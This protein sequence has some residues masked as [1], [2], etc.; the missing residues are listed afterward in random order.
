MNDLTQNSVLTKKAWHETL[1]G[2]G[3]MVTALAT[4]SGTVAVLY[5]KRR[6]RKAQEAKKLKRQKEA[7][8]MEEGLVKT[9]QQEIDSENELKRV[10][11]EIE[12]PRALILKSENGGGVPRIGKGVF[13]TIL[14]EASDT[15][16]DSVMNEVKRLP[17]D[18]SYNK[19]IIELVTNGMQIL[20]VD[21][22]E[23]GML[24]DIYLSDGIKY[25]IVVPI[26]TM[27]DMFI[28]A[29]FAWKSVLT[30]EMLIQVKSK[31]VNHANNIKNIYER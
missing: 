24:K 6:E 26:V 31:I 7:R 30:D 21:E 18:M 25:S 20:I 17:T 29:S 13:L 2:V 19:L 9:L 14:H 11:H 8:L 16:Y 15:G 22:M 3:T 4:A 23:D 10:K 5:N 28:Y 27:K 1:E 12:A